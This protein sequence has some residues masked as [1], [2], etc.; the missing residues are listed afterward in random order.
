MLIVPGVLF[1]FV[2]I[3]SAV[4]GAAIRSAP[5]AAIR[6]M[7]WMFLLVFWLAMGLVLL[8]SAIAA[9]EIIKSFDDAVA[10][11]CAGGI[12]VSAVFFTTFM[13]AATPLGREL[14]DGIAGMRLYLTVAEKDRMNMAGAPEMSPKHYEKLL[15]YAVALGVEKQWSTHFQKWL[16]AAGANANYDYKP[17]WYAGRDF[18]SR[19]F[20]NRMSAVSSTIS[21][22]IASSL[23]P[24]PSSSSSGFSSSSSSSSGGGSSGGGGGGGGG[25]GW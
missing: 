3:F 6:F 12:L 4:L 16:D 19:Q 5:N 13:G 21:T 15:P 2:S 23:P 14:M 8:V 10:L 20:G 25:G 17:Q 7:A 24:P 22:S 1:V 11:S 9:F 18:D